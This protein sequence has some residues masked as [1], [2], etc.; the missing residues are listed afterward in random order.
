MQHLTPTKGNLLFPTFNYKIGMCSTFHHMIWQIYIYCIEGGY[1]LNILL[2][3]KKKKF[4]KIQT[5]LQAN[6]KKA[7]TQAH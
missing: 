3:K 6:R 4:S 7:T 5:N 2:S 1:F